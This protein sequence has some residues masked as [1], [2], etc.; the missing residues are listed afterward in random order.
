MFIVG[1][2]NAVRHSQ[3]TCVNCYYIHI[4]STGQDKYDPEIPRA[5]SSMPVYMTVRAGLHTNWIM[6]CERLSYAICTAVR[7]NQS[8]P[9]LWTTRM[10]GG[11]VGLIWLAPLPHAHCVSSCDDLVSTVGKGHDPFVGA[12]RWHIS[13]HAG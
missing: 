11:L 2:H 10:A 12:W 4:F 7:R 1:S 8:Q 9:L 6:C 3:V 5:V 13:V